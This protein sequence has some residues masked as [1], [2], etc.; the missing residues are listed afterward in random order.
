MTR[1]LQPVNGAWC[2]AV[3]NWVL[4]MDR[5]FSAH[6]YSNSL[7]NQSDFEARISN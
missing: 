7:M 6:I 3:S 1:K 2:R 4:W 5:D